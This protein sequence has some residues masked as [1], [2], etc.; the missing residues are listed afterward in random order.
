MARKRRKK[1]GIVGC[2]AISGV[3]FRNLSQLFVNTEVVACA[4]ILPE[5]ARARAEEFGV[6]RACAVEELLADPGVEIVVNLTV[7]RAHAEVALAACRAGKHVHGEK[8]LAVSREEGAAVL[9]AAAAA[10]VRAGSAPDTFLGGGLQTCRKLI[11][12]GWI[13]RPVA[14]S[15]FMQC[16]GHE[17]WHP[18]PE[19]YYERGGGP[20]LDM[21]PYYLTA[22]VNLLGPVARVSGSVRSAFATRTITSR[23]KFGKVVKV[24]T[25]THVA[26]VVD[27]VQ[28]TVATVVTSFDVWAHQMPCIEVY[29]TEGTLAVPDPNTFGGPVVVRRHDSRSWLEMPLSHGHT[30]NCRG[31]GVADMAAAIDA[32]RPHR[33][34]GEL[35]MH[36]LDVMLAFEESS[37]AGRAVAVGTSCDRPAPLPM[38]LRDGELD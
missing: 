29:G 20:M 8:P 13:G 19:F 27:F 23:P 31:I 36:V 2:G 14:A 34:S 16:H 6:P 7:P 38:G 32:G 24:E 30:E 15:A 26:G 18:S 22:L 25:P 3:Y 21:G 4:D 33:A 37:R 28:G 1:V 11:D 17:S 12:E 5:R 10:G 35:A 9:A